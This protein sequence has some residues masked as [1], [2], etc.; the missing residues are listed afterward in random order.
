MI[1]ELARELLPYAVVLYGVDALVRVRQGERALLAPWGSRFRWTGTGMALRRPAAD[2]RSVPGRCAV[3]ACVR[4]GGFR[5]RG[6]SCRGAGPGGGPRAARR[7]GPVFEPA[8]RDRRAPVRHFVRS[9]SDGGVPVSRGS[10][11]GG[12]GDRGR[13]RSVDGDPR[14]RGARAPER[15]R[16]PARRRFRARSR[17]F[18]SSRGGARPEL[19]VARPVPWVAGPRRGLGAPR[20]GGVPAA[21]APGAVPSRRGGARGPR[22]TPSASAPRARLFSACCPRSASIPS[23]W[24]PARRRKTRWPPSSVRCA[25]AEYRAGFVRCTDCGVGLRPFASPGPSV[26]PAPR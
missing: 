22:H 13:R 12:D 20:P 16:D 2:L 11:R 17:A 19:P 15:R 24:P 14:R 21:R 25:T 8:L 18:L 5:G 7:A 9:P 10:L 1:V 23:R 4:S 6:P 26:S 3:G